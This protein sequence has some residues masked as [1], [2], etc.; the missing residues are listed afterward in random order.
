M[1]QAPSAIER[2]RRATAGAMRP[3]KRV[4]PDVWIEQRVKLS[5]LYEAA[6][7]PYDL[8]ARPWWREPL[9]VAGSPTT[10]GIRLKASPQTGKTL[11]L[12]ALILY[13]A[14]N[15]PASAMV[16]L[17][18]RDSAIEFR[19]RLYALADESGVSRPPRWKWNARHCEVGDMRVYLAWPKSR[20]R[21]RGRRC[22][23]VFRSEIDVYETVPRVGD[24]IES[25]NQRVKGFARHLILDE[26][27]P[28]PEP[29]RIDRLT[30]DSDFRHWWG[31]C[32]HCG[33]WQ[34]VR[35][36][37]H[38]S[39]LHQGRGGVVGLTDDEGNYLE[40]DDAAKR[41]YY[42]CV[43]RECKITNEDKPAFML[44]GRWVPAGQWLTEAGELAGVP[45][46]DAR[47]VGFHLWAAMSSETWGDM[48][49]EYLRARSQGLLA[50][51]FQNVLGLS[52]KTRAKMPTWQELGTRMAYT[53]SRGEIPPQAWFLTAGGDVQEREVYVSVRAWGDQRTSWLVDW[54]NFERSEGDEGEL[55][56]SDLAQ[57]SDHVLKR[58]WPIVGDGTN[59]RGQTTLRVVLLNI[60]ANHRTLDV[61]N[62]IK[63]LG[64][65]KRVRAVRG[66]QSVK[67]T[68]RYR[69][70]V[71]QHAKR[72]QSIRYEGGLQLWGIN[73]DV[74]RVD[75]AARFRSNPTRPGAWYV[76]ADC[77]QLGEWYLRQVVNEPQVLE[78][79]KDGRQRVIWKERDRTVGH[80]Y[81][82]CEVYSSAAAQMIVD[83]FP[84]QPGW[85]AVRWP[86]RQEAAVE[87]AAT[88]PAVQ[89]EF[90]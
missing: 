19:D 72:D 79:G 48:A 49:R 1:I 28:V 67:A 26:S 42:A 2:L 74:F 5:E 34:Q 7:G 38:S 63:S 65:T 88:E 59:P 27:S 62:W 52:F 20:Q 69:A 31:R 12:A 73:P 55:V 82:D 24:P 10:R 29:S 84:G 44:S 41:A 46:H 85:D 21:L 11:A 37:P 53:H 78:R 90:E 89:R 70:T 9:A 8:S 3:R 87:P 16:V 13:L 81:W 43:T 60:D 71:V 36:F 14:T 68:D 57:I 86:R 76:T 56:K 54:F 66:D 25:S 22:K 80:D 32:P 47:H 17:P 6:R 39:G 30:T 58:Q 50:D 75:L 83:G 15:S 35:F 51:C 4:E 23:Y 45:T 64:A 40:P 33:T 61:H 18:D 77:L